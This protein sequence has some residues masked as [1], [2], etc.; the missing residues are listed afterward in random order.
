MGNTTLDKMK[1]K[2]KEVTGDVTGDEKM[3]RE[4]QAE[5]I[6]A[7]VKDG[8]GKAVDAAKDLFK[9]KK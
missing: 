8:V 3:K 6:V 2:A 5:Q 9:G 7:Y 4:G 1:G